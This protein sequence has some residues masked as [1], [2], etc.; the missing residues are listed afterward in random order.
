MLRLNQKSI[1]ASG[2]G[3]LKK[4]ITIILFFVI[5]AIGFYV[6]QSNQLPPNTTPMSG[7]HSETIAWLALATSIVSLLIAIVGLVQKIIELRATEK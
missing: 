5:S 7:G 1:Y 6:Y 3:M 2:E 4:T